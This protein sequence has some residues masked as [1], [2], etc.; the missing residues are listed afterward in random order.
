MICEM[1]ENEDKLPNEDLVKLG[2]RIK[3]LRLKKGYTSYEYFALSII[4]PGP[5]S[6]DMK[7]GKIYDTQVY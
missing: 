3:E 4:S 5:N 7:K 1:K 6:A 2:N